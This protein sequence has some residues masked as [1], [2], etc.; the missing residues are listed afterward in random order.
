MKFI[1]NLFS[2]KEKESS[3]N[4]Q[5]GET[6]QEGHALLGEGVYMIDK[7]SQPVYQYRIFTNDELEVAQY[8]C[9]L[10]AELFTGLIQFDYEPANHPENLDEFL[11]LWGASGYEGFLGIERDQHIAFLSYNFGQYLVDHYGMKWQVK[12]DEVGEQTVVRTEHPVEL[13]MYPMDSTL[14]AIEEKKT[15]VYT[16][17][18]RKFED[19]L[20]RLKE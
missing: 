5:P 13:E 16:E 11:M 17:I 19:V 2:S 10:F 14:R 7:N 8:S 9:N 3:G 12:S 1:K 15:S 18:V 6:L 4:S 20:N